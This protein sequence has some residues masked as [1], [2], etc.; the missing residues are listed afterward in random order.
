[1]GKSLDNGIYLSDSKEIISKKVMNMYTDPGH[2]HVE[3]PGKVEGNV[4]FKYLDIFDPNK[5]EVEEL[6]KQYKK[7]GLGDVII[8]KRLIEVI[9]SIIEP[10]RTKRETLAKDKDVI[11]KILENGTK[12]AREVAKE[13]M[14]EVRKVMKINYFNL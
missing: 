7:G 14:S 12:K 2:I 3:D 4:V 13:T 1:M 8:K 11:M 10:I 5:E 9:E 6:K